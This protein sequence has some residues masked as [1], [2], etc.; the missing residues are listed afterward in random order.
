MLLCECLAAIS[1]H[2]NNLLQ[3]VVMDIVTII[4]D[5]SNSKD[6]H[7]EKLLVSIVMDFGGDHCKEYGK[8]SQI[9]VEVIYRYLIQVGCIGTV[10]YVA[11]R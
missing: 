10:Q 5:V 2:R 11:H 6:K 9:Y 4:K 7:R 3:G 8:W 1:S